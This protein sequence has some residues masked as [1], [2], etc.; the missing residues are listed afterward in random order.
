MGNLEIMSGEDYLKYAD[1]DLQLLEKIASSEVVAFYRQRKENAGR[2]KNIHLETRQ[3]FSVV[4][5]GIGDNAAAF[6]TPDHQKYIGENTLLD[7]S[8]S[9]HTARHEHEHQLNNIFHLNLNLLSPDDQKMLQQELKLEKPLDETTLIEGFNELS[10]FEKHGRH[11]KSGYAQKEVPLAE[12]LEELAKKHL[13]KSLLD[14]F[15]QGNSEAFMIMLQELS[16]RLQI[17]KTIG[18]FTLN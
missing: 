17:H 14:T 5:G 6:I 12:K 13:K 7:D 11:E 8:F 9:L 15:R 18:Q 10:T 1:L 16:V 2:L 3:Q 4:L